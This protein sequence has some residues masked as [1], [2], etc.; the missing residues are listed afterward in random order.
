MSVA[1]GHS[2]RLDHTAPEATMSDTITASDLD[3]NDRIKLHTDDF[4]ELVDRAWLATDG[5]IY[6]DF[7]SGDQE[8]F[9]PDEPVTICV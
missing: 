4:P 8:Q 3:R 5:M 6:V 7:A 1:R 2:K 9:R